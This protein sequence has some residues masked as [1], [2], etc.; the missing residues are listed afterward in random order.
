MPH[1]LYDTVVH[2]NL[3]YTNNT[4][5]HLIIIKLNDK[6]GIEMK[7][8]KYLISTALCLMSFSANAAVIYT[9]E[10]ICRGS[11][12]DVATGS[13]ALE[14]SYTPRTQ[15]P[16]DDFISFSYSSSP[17]SFEIPANPAL[18]RIHNSILP[19]SPD[20]AIAWVKWVKID[21]T[22]SGTGLNTWSINTLTD[23]QCP[24]DWG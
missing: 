7:Y 22:Q 24:A 10:D 18:N 9:F 13:L 8:L 11:C 17:G 15:V 3:I 14:N 16:D 23:Y 1:V 5:Q 4:W 2:H 6:N 19:T 21:V 12:S 20:T